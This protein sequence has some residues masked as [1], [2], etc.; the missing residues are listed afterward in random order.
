[1]WRPSLK[2]KF[3]QLSRQLLKFSHSRSRFSPIVVASVVSNPITPAGSF[4]KSVYS[5]FKNYGSGD[6]MRSRLREHRGPRGRLPIHLIIV[7]RA[8]LRSDRGDRPGICTTSR[9][10]LFMDA[11]GATRAHVLAAGIRARCRWCRVSRSRI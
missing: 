3:G 1:M 6:E 9:R 5:F 10:F 2:S 11:F 4:S 7:N 8:Y